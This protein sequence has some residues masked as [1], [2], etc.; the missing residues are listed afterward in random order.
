MNA[1]DKIDQVSFQIGQLLPSMRNNKEAVVL[2]NDM[3]IAAGKL[4]SLVGSEEK[5]Q[6]PTPD[7]NKLR[8]A[9]NL[10]L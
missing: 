3:L 9:L 5:Q 2:L 10:L 4:A 1:Q 7:L 8:A 6:V